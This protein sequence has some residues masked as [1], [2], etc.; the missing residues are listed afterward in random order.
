MTV[1]VS[2]PDMGIR[3]AHD[4]VI[5]PEIVGGH[6]VHSLRVG[7][8]GRATGVGGMS[9][10]NELS[11]PNLVPSAQVNFVA[12]GGSPARSDSCQI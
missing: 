8:D 11:Y 6:Q 3:A 10:L 4:Q 9:T 5:V 12:F 2:V 1:T 7:M